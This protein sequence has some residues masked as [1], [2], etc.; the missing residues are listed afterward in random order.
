MIQHPKVY[1]FELLEGFRLGVF[2]GVLL[3]SRCR[4]SGFPVESAILFGLDFNAI[5]H[6]LYLSYYIIPNLIKYKILNNHCILLKYLYQ[7]ELPHP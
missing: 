5:I 4:R 7:S 6:L 2:P 1:F 3:L